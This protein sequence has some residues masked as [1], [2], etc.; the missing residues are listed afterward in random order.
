MDRLKDARARYQE[1]IRGLR[2]SEKKLRSEQAASQT[3]HL[4]ERITQLEAEL[5]AK[6]EEVEEA[7]TRI[8]TT[9]KNNKR[10]A[11]QNKAL[12]AQ[13]VGRVEPAPPQPTPLQD[14]TNTPTSPSKPLAKPAPESRF[15]DRLARF[16]PVA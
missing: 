15:R 5:T 1:Q 8:L 14:R 7:D 10:L 11:A 6:A 3:T 2:A 4:E 13:L 12:Q 9:L 16:K